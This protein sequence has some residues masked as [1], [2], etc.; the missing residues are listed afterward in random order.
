MEREKWEEEGEKKE[1]GESLEE[2]GERGKKGSFR[3]EEEEEEEPEA[4]TT[5]CKPPSTS[6][7]LRR[8]KGVWTGSS[9][10]W[11]SLTELFA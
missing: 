9:V 11:V 10:C 3:A 2:E 7:S 8:L 5:T 1:E 6:Q 4:K